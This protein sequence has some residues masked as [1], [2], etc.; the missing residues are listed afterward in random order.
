MFLQNA[1]LRK[2]FWDFFLLREDRDFFAPLPPY[3]VSDIVF[4]ATL[5]RAFSEKLRF[6]NRNTIA[7][8]GSR[9]NPKVSI[10]NPQTTRRNADRPLHALCW[11]VGVCSWHQHQTRLKCRATNMIL[12]CPSPPLRFSGTSDPDRSENRDLV[13]QSPVLWSETEDDVV[14]LRLRV[15]VN[16]RWQK[17]WQTNLWY[18]IRLLAMK[19]RKRM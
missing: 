6:F 11:A 17:K 10:Y 15:N 4:V 2:R 16:W 12:N 14:S 9:Y 5:T 18:Q 1:F 7:S 13:L 3:M 8:A 19:K